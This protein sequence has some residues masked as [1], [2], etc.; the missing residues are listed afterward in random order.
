M[1]P[2]II[3]ELNGKVIEIR[4]SEDETDTGNYDINKTRTCWKERW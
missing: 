1:F 3:D 4:I 2:F